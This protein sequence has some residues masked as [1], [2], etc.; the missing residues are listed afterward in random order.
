[1]NESGHNITEIRSP[2][3]CGVDDFAIRLKR[4]SVAGSV[5]VLLEKYKDMQ[6]YSINLG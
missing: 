2:S 3:I 5:A 1:M 6:F 4:R